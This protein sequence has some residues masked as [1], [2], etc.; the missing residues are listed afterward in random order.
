[1]SDPCD[2]A[3]PPRRDEGGARPTLRRTRCALH[4]GKSPLGIAHYNFK[5]GHRSK[6]LWFFKHLRPRVSLPPPEEG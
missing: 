3:E 2:H 5:H 1:M 4:G 6:Y